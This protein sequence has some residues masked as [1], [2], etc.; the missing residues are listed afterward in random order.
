MH[1]PPILTTLA[2]A[3][4]TLA[5]PLS[6]PAPQQ[7]AG[8]FAFTSWTCDACATNNICLSFPHEGI[9]QGECYS[10]EPGQA[11]L[12]VYQ[13]ITPRCACKSCFSI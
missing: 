1:F 8:S 4:A 6:S 12:T 13:S 5:I 7:D 9:V 2:L 3:A 11:S 10:L